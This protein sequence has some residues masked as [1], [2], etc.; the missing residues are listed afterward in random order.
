MKVKSRI[1]AQRA[2][3]SKKGK[4]KHQT[5]VLNT[6]VEIQG[7]QGNYKEKSPGRRHTKGHSKLTKREAHR[8]KYTRKGKV[9]RYR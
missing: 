3:K 2:N 4:G 6:R 7:A 8:L 5:R 1:S 9:R